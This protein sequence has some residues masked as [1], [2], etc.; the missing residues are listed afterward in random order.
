MDLSL[1]FMF[2]IHVDMHRNLYQ[3]LEEGY[4]CHEKIGSWI[5]HILCIT[6][7][8]E[9]L[10]E[11]MQLDGLHFTLNIPTFITRVST[12]LGVTTSFLWTF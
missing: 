3:G 9:V 7:Q 1:V 11:I 12:P 4:P 2:N 8:W 10:D 6:S 5:L